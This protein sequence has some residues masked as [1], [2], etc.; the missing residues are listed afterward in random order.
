MIYDFLNI[1]EKVM[2]N[3]SSYWSVSLMLLSAF[4]LLVVTTMKHVSHF[5]LPSECVCVGELIDINQ[6]HAFHIQNLVGLMV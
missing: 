3:K 4:I 1:W 5:W 2:M 6:T